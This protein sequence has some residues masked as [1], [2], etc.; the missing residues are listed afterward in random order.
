MKDFITF[1]RFF[2][3]DMTD[4]QCNDIYMLSINKL[5]ELARMLASNKSPNQSR[6]QDDSMSL[7]QSMN[8]PF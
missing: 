2:Q 1:V 3:K 7:D 4:S 6:V 5:T 8:N